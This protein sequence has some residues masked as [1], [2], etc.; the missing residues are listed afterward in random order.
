MLWTKSPNRFRYAES[1]D[2]EVVC[3]GTLVCEGS[4]PV[5]FPLL[6]DLSPLSDGLVS[7]P[8]ACKTL[9]WESSV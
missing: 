4:L 8:D 3:F 7:A 5:G 2:G 6:L 9:F 1:L